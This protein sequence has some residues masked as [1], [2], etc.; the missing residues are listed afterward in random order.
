M[1]ALCSL[2]LMAAPLAAMASTGTL[3]ILFLGNS[4]TSVNNVPEL[5]RRLAQTSTKPIDIRYE[6]LGGGHLEDSAKSQEVF[7][8][9]KKGNFN[10]VVMQAAMVSMSHQNDYPQDGAIAIARAAVAAGAKVLMYPEWSRQGIEETEYTERVYRSV[11]ETVK[12]KTAPVGRVWD[13]VLRH[14]RLDLWSPD[15]NH[16]SLDGSFL[17]A[18]VLYRW[19]VQDDNAV[20]SY[21]PDGVSRGE[22]DLFQ[23]VTVAYYRRL[24]NNSSH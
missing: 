1:K 17:A 15:G 12:G 5:V 24:N 19:I 22:A 2:L 16:A 7:D 21:F 6:L 8:K 10:Y 9:I 23:A 20:T 14:A 4:H 11:G 13:E 18:N 3:K